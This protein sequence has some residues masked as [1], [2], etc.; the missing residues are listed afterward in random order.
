MRPVP[1]RSYT[2]FIVEPGALIFPLLR[3]PGFPIA[4]LPRSTAELRLEVVQ[5][6]LEPMFFSVRVGYDN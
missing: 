3:R 6:R 2:V 5:S 1:A 4:P